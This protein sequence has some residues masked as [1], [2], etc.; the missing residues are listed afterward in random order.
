MA[1]TCE[2]TVCGDGGVGTVVGRPP[3]RCDATT[4]PCIA[5]ADDSDAASPATPERFPLT[6]ELCVISFDST[7][8]C[9]TATRHPNAAVLFPII[10]SLLQFRLNDFRKL[11]FR[12]GQQLCSFNLWTRAWLPHGSETSQPKS[13]SYVNFL[14]FQDVDQSHLFLE[15]GKQV[16]LLPL[17]FP[18]SPHNFLFPLTFLFQHGLV[19][20]KL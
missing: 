3:K 9:H 12:E 1:A 17:Q 16:H 2:G 20:I 6:F 7:P 5:A 4:E 8:P 15:S 18:N 11:V 13:R 19:T 14:A 10:F